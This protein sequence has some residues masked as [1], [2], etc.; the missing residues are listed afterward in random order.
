MRHPLCVVPPRIDPSTV[1][2][3]TERLDEAKRGELV[4]CA[5]IAIY[6]DSYDVGVIGQARRQP[7][8]SRAMA[9]ELFDHLRDLIRPPS[10]R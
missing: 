10:R 3:L 7:T 9:L 8:L 5:C 4:G 6:R 2:Y 1:A